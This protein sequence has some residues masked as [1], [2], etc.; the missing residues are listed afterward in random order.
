MGSERP[1]WERDTHSQIIQVEDTSP[2]S[3][4]CHKTTSISA[5]RLPTA[6]RRPTI[7]ATFATESREVMSEDSCGNYEHI[8][9]LIASDA[10]GNT[11]EHTFTITVADTEAPEFVEE[12]PQNESL[13]CSDGIPAAA[14]LSAR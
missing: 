11:T 3:S 5:K 14:V 8:V 7:A 9:T 4:V 1:Q 13:N 2:S 10:C 6:R 12:L